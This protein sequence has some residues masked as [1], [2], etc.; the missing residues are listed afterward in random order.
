MRFIGR[1]IPLISCYRLADDYTT[2]PEPFKPSFRI[3]LIETKF[4]VM[5]EQ[6]GN[7]SDAEHAVEIARVRVGLLGLDHDLPQG[8]VLAAG[9]RSNS[10]STRTVTLREVPTP[11]TVV[12]RGRERA[13]ISPRW[14]L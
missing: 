6:C 7:G 13:L 3:K 9:R 10:S 4:S 8:Q 14:R 5:R 11:P 12:S 2:A 1:A